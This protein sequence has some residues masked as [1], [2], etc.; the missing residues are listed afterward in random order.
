MLKVK[1]PFKQCNCSIISYNEKENQPINLPLSVYDDYKL[2]LKNKD[3]KATGKFLIVGNIWDFDNI[4]VSKTLSFFENK[5]DNMSKL[6]FVNP[7]DNKRYNI[8][9][10]F[11]YLIC[12]DCEKGPLGIICKAKLLNDENSTVIELNLLSLDSIDLC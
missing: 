7:I 6:E 11:K 3:T 8:T 5:D 2:L 12:S 9:Q 4:G 1:C 10:I